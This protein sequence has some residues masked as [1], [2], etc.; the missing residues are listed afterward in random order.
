MITEEE[1]QKS[2]KAIKSFSPG[3]PLKNYIS[4]IVFPRFKNLQPG[5]RLDFDFPLTALV[6]PN[7]IGK[8]SVLHALWG[9]P[10]G[11]STSRFW[12]ETHLDPIEGE[13]S[14]TQR[15][16]YA[17]WNDEY[18]ATVET[19]KNRVR[20]KD[21]YKEYWE[22]ARI[23][24]NDGM[25]PLPSGNYPGKK[26]D[27]WN[28]VNRDVIYINLKAIF[29]GFDRY[30]YFSNDDD[31]RDRSRIRRASKKLRD[32]K[33]NGLQS[34]VWYKRERVHE[35]RALEKEELE[36]VSI[37][38]GRPYESAHIIAHSMYPEVKGQDFTVIF[39]RGSE[40]SEAFAGSGELSVVKLVT[41]IL[42][43]KDFSLV[44]LD[45][46]ETSLHPGAQ[47]QLLYFLLTQIKH[48]KL[49]IV[50]STHSPDL[51]LGL[52]KEAVVAFDDLGGEKTRALVGVAPNI[53]FNRLGKAPPNSIRV[54]VEDELAKILVERARE[55]LDEGDREAIEVRI[56]PGGASAMLSQLGP[57]AML[58]DNDI[59]L[60]LDGDQKKV[61]NFSRR[62]DLKIDEA[63]DPEKMA[64][65]F[66]R[67]IGVKPALHIPG[68]DPESHIAG[69]IK[70]QN[71]YLKWIGTHVHYLPCATPEACFLRANNVTLDRT[72]HG[73]EVKEKF[74]DFIRDGSKVEL[75]AEEINTLAKIRAKQIPESS[76]CVESIA[77]TLRAMLS[78]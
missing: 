22:P 31:P 57:A 53:A 63:E 21:R 32:I 67:E 8:T 20:R 73:A 27:R 43:A 74:L 42:S 48:K 33:A 72:P 6:G 34:Y 54:F 7:G 25:Q 46:P 68:G 60:L 15:F 40:Y 38:L 69:K 11:Y 19:R 47:R 51:I 37:I 26:K 76:E 66:M 3:H 65:L 30:F 28:P 77:S 24:H 70:A 1:I 62:E 41:D 75:T 36:W 18:G 49:Q 16:F 9:A 17:H 55:T 39:K 12:F 56:A 5:T 58:S 44:L 59:H 29:G 4:Y 52:P 23:R 50:I 45:E 61:E 78:H 35:N 13:G 71:E 64:S 2:I 14:D 10:F